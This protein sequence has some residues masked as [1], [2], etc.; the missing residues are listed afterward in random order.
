MYFL[1][2]LLSLEA[3]MVL[4]SPLSTMLE[5][6]VSTTAEAEALA[7]RGLVYLV[8]LICLAVVWEAWCTMRQFGV[9]DH[10]A[11]ICGVGLMF[12]HLVRHVD[13]YDSL[14]QGVGGRGTLEAEILVLVV[15][16]VM[17]VGVVLM[18]LLS[19]PDVAKRIR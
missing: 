17:P 13:T 5:V 6:L 10:L 15:F 19:L 8:V 4:E 3:L 7:S 12:S 11:Y 1:V 14:F 9:L 18:A 2:A 16:V